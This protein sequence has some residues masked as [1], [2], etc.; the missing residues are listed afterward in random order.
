MLQGLGGV[1]MAPMFFQ[2]LSAEES[3]GNDTIL[4]CVMLAGG[5]D[6]LNTVIPLPHYGQYYKLRT[7]ATPPCTT[8]REPRHSITAYGSP[9]EMRFNASS[10]NTG[11]NE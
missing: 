10:F 4:V 3:Q 11:P 5:N 2:S 1:A 9:P 6:G 8:G 7:P